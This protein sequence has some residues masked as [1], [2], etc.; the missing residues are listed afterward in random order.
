LHDTGTLPP[1]SFRRTG[2]AS[3]PLLTLNYL[4]VEFDQGRFDAG[5]FPYES[6]EQ[7]TDLRAELSSSHVVV[8]EGSRIVCVPVVE[9]AAVVGEQTTF[10]VSQSRLGLATPLLREAL[11]RILTRGW[12]FQLRRYAP[13]TF[14]SRRPGRDILAKAAAQFG[15]VEGLHVFPQFALDVRRSGPTRRPGICDWAEGPL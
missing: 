13:P 10:E 3:G 5:T 8:R 9:A 7:L 12:G 4:P 1:R 15:G 6:S 2:S 14:V 11:I